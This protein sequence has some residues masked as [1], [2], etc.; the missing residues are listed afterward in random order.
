VASCGIEAADALALPAQQR[1]AALRR[2]AQRY[3]R[4][5]K[6]DRQDLLDALAEGRA[7]EA[8]RETRTG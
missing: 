6:I 3:A 5:L 7:A 8:P 2:V 1:Q 4:A